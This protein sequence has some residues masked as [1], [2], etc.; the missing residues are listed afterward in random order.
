MSES[1]LALDSGA[2][3]T[4]PSEASSQE[5]A[6]ETSLELFED[7]TPTEAQSDSTGHSGNA[8]SDFDPEKHDWLRGNADDV[9]EQYQPLLPLAKNMQAQ[10][11][12]TQQDLADQRRAVEA[13]QSEWANRVQ[14]LVTPQQQQADPVDAMRA[15]LTEDEARGVDAVEQIIQHRVGNAV[16]DL[17]SQ[18]QQLQA[19]LQQANQYV[20]GQQTAH[21]ATQVGEARERYG[22]DLDA[23]TDQIVATTKITNPSTGSPYTVTEAYELHAGV[24]AQKAA[25]LRENDTTARKSSKRAVRGTQGVD[26]TESS[27]PLSDSDVLSGLSK[28]GFE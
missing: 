24:T 22:S 23:Y 28:L 17:N 7:A 13:Q 8:Q 4:S 5:Q 1:A 3:D 20:Q 2:E 16:N 14:T 15:N 18:M 19:Q 9:P 25:D 21:I 12:R 11:T 6:T 27:G 10:F 26:A